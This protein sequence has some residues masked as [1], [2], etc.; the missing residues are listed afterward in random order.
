MK[1]NKF[2]FYNLN[3]KLLKSKVFFPI[4]RAFVFLPLP[5]D[6]NN[7]GG[8]GIPGNNEGATGQAQGL[9]EGLPPGLGSIWSPNMEMKGVEIKSNPNSPQNP[10]TVQ[11]KKL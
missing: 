1:K 8:V 2:T 5:P 9:L 7:P 11:L 4:L 6:P 3:P 10:T